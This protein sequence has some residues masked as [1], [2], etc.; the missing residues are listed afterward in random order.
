MRGIE[1]A[2]DEDRAIQMQDRAVL[3][4]LPGVDALAGRLDVF[5]DRLVVDGVEMQGVD[6]DT[7]VRLGNGEGRDGL[8]A[9]DG[10]HRRKLRRPS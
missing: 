7:L 6:A 2:L 3:A 1:T 4:A 10:A 9:P 5:G 8:G